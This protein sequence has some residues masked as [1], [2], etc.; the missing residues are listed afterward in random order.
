[1][2]GLWEERGKEGKEEGVG[3]QGEVL[4]RV[5]VTS[6]EVRCYRVNMRWI[7]GFYRLLK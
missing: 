7:K 2:R 4:A 5:G 1:V 6:E 3:G